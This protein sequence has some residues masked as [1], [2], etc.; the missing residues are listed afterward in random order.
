NPGVGLSMANKRS[1][2]IMPIHQPE[3]MPGTID[4]CIGQRHPP[5]ALVNSGQSDICVADVKDRISGYQG[6]GVAVRPQAQVNEVEDRWG[7]GDL[8]E[9]SG[10][11][12]GCGFQVG[13]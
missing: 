2:L 7:A 8:Q 12:L 3:D 5:P 9:S 4:Y 10:M 13:R 1:S 6:S 11:G